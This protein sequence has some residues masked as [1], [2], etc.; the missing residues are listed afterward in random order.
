MFVNMVFELGV[1]ASKGVTAH[2]HGDTIVRTILSAPVVCLCCL[3]C[4][5]DM[6]YVCNCG[7]RRQLGQFFNFSFDA[8]EHF[9]L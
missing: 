7:A 2:E 4:G 8:R 1:A 6:L 3:R 9:D 5:V